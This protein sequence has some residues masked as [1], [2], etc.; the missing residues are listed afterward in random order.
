MLC[1][2]HQ[3][4]EIVRDFEGHRI[5]HPSLVDLANFQVLHEEKMA[6]ESAQ[7]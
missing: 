4:Q 5:Q 7:A 2:E 6:D 3:T 1:P